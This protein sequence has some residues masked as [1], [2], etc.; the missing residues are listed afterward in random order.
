[1]TSHLVFLPWASRFTSGEKPAHLMQAGPTWVLS[2]LAEEETMELTLPAR[3]L[4]GYSPAQT[5]CLT[6][7]ETQPG[8]S[9]ISALTSRFGFFQKSIEI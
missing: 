6:L 8:V 7:R 2:A 9:T 5:G 1:M 4:P 3:L